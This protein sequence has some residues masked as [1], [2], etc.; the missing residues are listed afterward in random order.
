M[1]HTI[2]L[3]LAASAALAACSDNSDQAVVENV[4]TADIEEAPANDIGF[5]EARETGPLASS[6]PPPTRP[7]QNQ[8]ADASAEPIPSSAGE[9]PVSMPQIAYRY[10]LGFRL[11]ADAIKPL[12]EKHA[13]M[14]VAR[15]PQMCRIISMRQADADGDYAYGSLQLAVAA[16]IAR[17]FSNELEKS[18]GS[19]DGELVSSSIEGED[20][21]KQIVDTEARLRARTL[22]RDRL[23]EVL[24]TRRGSVKELV[25]AERGVAQVNQEIDQAQSWLNEMR[26][27]VAFSQMAISYESGQRSAG[28]FA[29]PIRDAW[30][31][32]GSIFGSMIAFLILALATLGPLALLAFAGWK[33]WRGV[34]GN[35]EGTEGAPPEDLPTANPS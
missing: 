32:L 23:M 7:V 11:P 28:G 17:E 30:N 22:L 34:R 26:G 18:S 5:M 13:D 15:G 3:V 31:S 1:R 2:A 4:T 12:Q 14:C 19:V 24:R 27:R 29:E 35:R 25:E 16:E 10:A 33:I 9:I 6:P 20:L 21:S 8:A